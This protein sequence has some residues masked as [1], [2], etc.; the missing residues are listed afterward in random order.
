MSPRLATTG[1][2]KEDV[3]NDDVVRRLRQL[4]PGPLLTVALCLPAPAVHAWGPVAHR[5]VTSKAIDTLPKGIKSFYKRHRLEI[6]T[7]S[8]EAEFSEEGL[9]RRFAVDRVLPFPFADLPRAEEDL[10]SRFG[11]E[12]ADLGRLPWL[13]HESYSRLV[14]AFESRDKRRILVESDTLSGLLTDLHNPLA[15]TQN[16]DGQMTEQHGLWVR[17]GTRLPEAM[18]KRLKLKPDAAHF[19]DEPEEH[20]FSI[21]NR[22]YV[23]I[24]NLLYHEEL[25]RRGLGGYTEIY[26]ASLEDRVSD[27]VKARLSRAATEVGSYWYT[28]WTKA[29]RPKLD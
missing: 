16:A 11:E 7:L 3:L 6:P 27:L 26:Y 5:L 10:R 18:E 25:A 23:W 14:E 9:D 22:N 20:V 28:A 1:Q 24:D 2:M 21:V 19:L 29:A 15:L 4:L 8:P 12:A 13:I 17:F